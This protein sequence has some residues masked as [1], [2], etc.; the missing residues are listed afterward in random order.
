MRRTI[1]IELFKYG[2]YPMLL[3]V[4]RFAKEEDYEMCQLIIDVIEEHNQKYELN[5]PTR[6]GE[7]AVNYLKLAFMVNHNLMGDIAYR[8]SERYAEDIMNAIN[9]A[10]NTPC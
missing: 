5:L 6:L 4:E 10:K 8:N 1:Q 7:D 3:V 2:F 9:E